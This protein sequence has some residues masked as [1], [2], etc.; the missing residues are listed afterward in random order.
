LIINLPAMRPVAEART[1]AEDMSFRQAP[2]IIVALTPP[3]LAPGFSDAPRDP[4]MRMAL[5]FCVCAPPDLHTSASRDDRHDMFGK[6]LDPEF[7]EKL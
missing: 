2:A 6:S 7:P 5:G 1:E 4:V 3:P